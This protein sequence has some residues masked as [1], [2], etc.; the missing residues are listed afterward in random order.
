MRAFHR[1]VGQVAAQPPR[2]VPAV[3]AVGVNRGQ[4]PMTAAPA[5]GMAV[6]VAGG[7]GGEGWGRTGGACSSPPARPCSSPSGPAAATPCPGAARASRR[8]AGGGGRQPDCQ[9]ARADTRRQRLVCGRSAQARTGSV[10]ITGQ[11]RHGTAAERVTSEREGAGAMQRENSHG[12]GVYG[13]HSGLAMSVAL[14]DSW[15][16]RLTEPELLPGSSTE[17]GLAW[18]AAAA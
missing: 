12:K 17:C 8:C 1:L 3:E 13:G 16:L 18:D 6:A 11:A 5:G 2:D 4:H 10:P 9:P 15:R 14:S 7:G